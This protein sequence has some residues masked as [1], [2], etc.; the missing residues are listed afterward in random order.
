MVFR[1]F[2]AGDI[3]IAQIEVLVHSANDSTRFGTDFVWKIKWVQYP[4]NMYMK[5]INE[6]KDEYYD[7]FEDYFSR[8]RHV[9]RK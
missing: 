8:C 6:R 5:S 3:K 4:W 2:V 9:E 7:G 1:W